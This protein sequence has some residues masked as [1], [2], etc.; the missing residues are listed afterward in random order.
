M[1]IGRRLDTVRR[2]GVFSAR[3]KP[4]HIGFAWKPIY[5]YDDW[6]VWLEWVEFGEEEWWFKGQQYGSVKVAVRLKPYN[7]EN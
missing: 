6:I 3:F 7:K 1:I 4:T 2:T 5:T